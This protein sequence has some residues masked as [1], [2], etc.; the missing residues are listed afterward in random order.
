MKGLQFSG[1]MAVAACN[2]TK[3]QTRRTSGLHHVNGADYALIGIDG[4]CATF[5]MSR[6]PEPR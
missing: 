5:A 4:A 3:T 6:T 1:A 2:G